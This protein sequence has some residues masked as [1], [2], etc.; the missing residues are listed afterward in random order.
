[1]AGI[2]PSIIFLVTL[3]L[4]GIPLSGI[5]IFLWPQLEQ[6]MTPTPPVAEMVL[7]TGFTGP[8][9]IVYDA[10][11]GEASALVD[12]RY[13]L[14]IPADGTL[15]LS[16]LEPLMD[17]T[18]QSA[19]YEDGTRLPYYGEAEFAGDTVAL[20]RGGMII[21]RPSGPTINRSEMRPQAYFFYVGRGEEASEF[22]QGPGTIP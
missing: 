17:G 7:P 20:R 11:V 18:L 10:Q 2:P 6:A 14:R 8:V 12:G 21:K 9:W 4:L 3:G 22:F 1:M 19:C 13:Q 15:R 5:L 16:S